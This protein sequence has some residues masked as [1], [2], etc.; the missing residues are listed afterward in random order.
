MEEEVE[1]EYFKGL[2]KDGLDPKVLIFLK[3]LADINNQPVTY[4]VKAS[5]EEFVAYLSQDSIPNEDE[6]FNELFPTRH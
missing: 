5:L 1:L 2:I 6:E 4:F 3:T